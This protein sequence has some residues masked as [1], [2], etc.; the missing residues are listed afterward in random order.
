MHFFNVLEK[1]AAAAAM[2]FK[3]IYRGSATMDISAIG[4][5]VFFP[6]LYSFYICKRKK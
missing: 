5:L 1:N 6:F 3:K 2:N 4:V